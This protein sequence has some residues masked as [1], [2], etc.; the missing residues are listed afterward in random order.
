[1]SGQ[2]ATIVADPPW[3]VM[4]G[5]LNGREGFGDAT[6]SSRPLAYPSMTVDEIKALQ[7]SAIAA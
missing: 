2:Y 3:K 5:P 6:G 7:V 1:M 4:A